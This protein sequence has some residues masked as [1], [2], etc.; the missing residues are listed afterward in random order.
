MEV[1]N[2]IQGT[3]EWHAH[4]ASHF[5]ASDAPAM[6]GVSPY[7]SRNELLTELSTGYKPEVDAA[8]QRR[9]NDGHT[10]EDLARPLAEQIIGES[11]YPVTGCEGKLSASFDGLTMAEDI[12]FEHKTLNENLRDVM[13]HGCMG[14]DLDLSYRIQMQQQC[15][16]AGCERVLFMAS[17]WAPS[18]DETEHFVTL[19]DGSVQYYS[20][21]EMRHCWYESNAAL[22]EKINQGW[23]QFY[24]DLGNYIPEPEVIA[25]VGK[26]PETLPALLIEV[27]GMVT[28]SNLAQYKEHALAVFASVNRDLVTDQDFADARKAIKWAGEVE[29]RLQSAKQHALSQTASIDELFRTIDEIA[30]EARRVRLDLNNCVKVRDANL[31]TE[32]VAE[33]KA[34]FD[35]HIAA[36]NKRIGRAWMPAVP[37]DFAAAIKGMSK[38]ENMRGA[39]ATALANAKI[40]ANKWADKITANKAAI[41]AESEFA[42]LFADASTLVLKDPE[43]VAMAIQTRVSAQKEK[44]AAEAERVRAK[45]IKDAA[46]LEAA[47]IK[48]LEAL[49]AQLVVEAPQAPL[50][51]IEPLP[52]ILNVTDSLR[53]YAADYNAQ[54]KKIDPTNPSWQSLRDELVQL[55]NGLT[56]SQLASVIAVVRSRYFPEEQAA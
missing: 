18:A 9:F 45:A 50:P 10:F 40:A 22:A 25:P 35:E 19:P 14:E 24:L 56:T 12:A 1:T 51:V 26:S 17:K 47:E 42:A 46:D 16:V 43:F 6:M 53:Q 7:K 20:L 48:R 15:M 44:Q 13:G 5:N 3:P 33:G 27:T 29:T 28:A 52:V 54:Q 39:V 21:V 4:R 23:V 38:Y 41:E 31:R 32:I 36:C 11:L 8:T 55:A 37:A 30:A 34:A 2:L 49:N